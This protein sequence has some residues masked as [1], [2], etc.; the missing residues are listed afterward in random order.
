MTSTGRHGGHDRAAGAVAA[1]S[2]A[3]TPRPCAGSH[4]SWVHDHVMLCMMVWWNSEAGITDGSLF[5][6][7]LT[8]GE[9]VIV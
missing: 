6:F 3:P 8:D 7:A 1:V 5:N 2:T 9:T 4:A